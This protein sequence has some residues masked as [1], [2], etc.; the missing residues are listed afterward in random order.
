KQAQKLRELDFIIWD[1]ISMV[2]KCALKA[3][4]Q[5]FRDLTGCTDVPFGGKCVIVGGD[6]GQTLPVVKN[7]SRVDVIN[8]SV[9]QYEHWHLFSKFSLSVNVRCAD[10]EYN[11]FLHSLAAGALGTFSDQQNCEKEIPIDAKFLFP[12]QDLD[13]F[14]DHFFTPE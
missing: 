8:M 5:L 10:P 6:F 11:R 3:V 9:K 14:I 1:E 12:H 2:P 7:G 4:D 13:S